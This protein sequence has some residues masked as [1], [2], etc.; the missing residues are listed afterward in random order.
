MKKLVKYFLIG[1]LDAVSVVIPRT[2]SLVERL[3]RPEPDPRSPRAFLADSVQGALRKPRRVYQST[4][5]LYQRPII[6]PPKDVMPNPDAEMRLM[7]A[8]IRYG[9]R[10]L[11]GLVAS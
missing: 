10:V 5:P 4:W 3:T 9:N 8:R 1:L 6:L 11:E 2:T 7:V